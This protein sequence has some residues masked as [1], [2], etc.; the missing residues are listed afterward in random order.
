MMF[1]LNIIIGRRH[2]SHGKAEK[3][4]KMR[5]QKTFMEFFCPLCIVI[6]NCPLYMQMAGQGEIGYNSAPSQK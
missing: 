2:I 6:C 3:Q 4:T 5:K 1:E